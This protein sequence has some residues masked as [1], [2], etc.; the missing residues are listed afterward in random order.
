MAAS[1][2]LVKD[3]LPDE[4]I[5]PYL[6]MVLKKAELETKKVAEMKF[7]EFK[8]RL[9]DLE[10]AYSTA[11]YE[12]HTHME[13]VISLVYSWDAEFK[14]DLD[15]CYS[16][17]E[18]KI[19]KEM[20]YLK[21]LQDSLNKG[22]SDTKV[23]IRGSGEWMRGDTVD[24][25]HSI[26]KTNHLT[27]VI[28]NIV[29]TQVKDVP[30]LRFVAKELE[31]NMLCEKDRRILGYIST[32]S[33]LPSDLY[34]ARIAISHENFIYKITVPEDVEDKERIQDRIKCE[35]KQGGKMPVYMN[36]IRTSKNFE[37]KFECCV[38]ESHTVSAFLF[39]QHING[40]P[41][42]FMPT[43]L[44]PN[45][46]FVKDVLKLIRQ[47]KRNKLWISAT[48]LSKKVHYCCKMLIQNFIKTKTFHLRSRYIVY[49]WKSKSRPP[50]AISGEANL[51]LK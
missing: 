28:Y 17:E 19:K 38:H 45:E 12:L 32:L 16:E 37:L 51:W 3:D 35:L 31:T 44:I 22:I 40:S 25:Q 34:L 1:Y 24:Q 43:D 13:K 39:N 23:A 2:P 20:E 15:S 50:N 4:N 47:M 18:S 10:S 14:K 9:K 8:N 11:L 6:D 21:Q 30:P 7:S 41:A 29:K 27:E 48:N 33:V 36:P 42:V 5:Q 49:H 26:M 46:Y